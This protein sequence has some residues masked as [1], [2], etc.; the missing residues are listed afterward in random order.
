MQKNNSHNNK[1]AQ[2]DNVAGLELKLAFVFVKVP[3][4]TAHRRGHLNLV[5][6]HTL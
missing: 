2:N 5:L 3:E 4:Q 6:S 1:D